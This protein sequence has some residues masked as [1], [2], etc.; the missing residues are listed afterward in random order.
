[1]GPAGLGRPG[2]ADGVEGVG[3]ALAAAVLPVAAV[4]LHDPDTGRGDVAG[5][6]GA[7]AAGTFDP[8]QAHGPE[9]A[10]PA[11]EAAVSGRGGREFPDPQQPSDRVERSRDVHVRV[12]VHAAGDGAYF[13]ASLYDGHS[14]PFLRL[15]DGTHPLAV[16]PVNPGL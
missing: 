10:Q 1:M 9:P 8:D 6:A 16:G 14:H 11:Q 2:R 5:Q 13:S 3:L 4:N 15:R 12:G 7:V